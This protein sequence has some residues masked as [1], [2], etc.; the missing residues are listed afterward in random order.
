MIKTIM[1]LK[2]RPGMSVEAFRA[3]Y[4]SKHRVIGEKYLKGRAKK[5]QRRF[6]AAPPDPVTGH[7]P[8]TEYDVLLEVWYSDR[9]AY[10]TTMAE[11]TKPEARLEIEEDESHLFDAQRMYFLIAPRERI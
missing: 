3:Y 4:E 6:L 1:L 11:L 2:R 10:E 8:E 5:Y 7:R 9:D